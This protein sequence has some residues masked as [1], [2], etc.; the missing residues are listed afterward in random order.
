MKIII[1]LRNVARSAIL[2]LDGIC[3]TRGT[4]RCDNRCACSLVAGIASETEKKH[5]H[6][7]CCRTITARAR[8]RRF[9]ARKSIALYSF[10]AICL[11][12]IAG[13][14]GE[15]WLAI[16]DR[17]S[18]TEQL[19]AV[20]L[21]RL[22]AA[23]LV[24][25]SCDLGQMQHSSLPA[26]FHCSGRELAPRNCCCAYDRCIR[27]AMAVHRSAAENKGT[28]K[29]TRSPRLCNYGAQDYTSKFEAPVLTTR[30]H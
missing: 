13:C 8:F 4:S 16:L 18:P 11:Y 7:R 24:Q 27:R 29:G 15:L 3:Q 28:K 14:G 30:A 6:T 25:V 20:C 2:A 19:V 10:I 23:D 1:V 17:T 12:S 26:Q 21:A 5:T 9:R 22:A